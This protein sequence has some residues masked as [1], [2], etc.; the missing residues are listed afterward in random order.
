MALPM[1]L[2]GRNSPGRIIAAVGL[3]LI[4]ISLYRD[5]AERDFPFKLG[6]AFVAGGVFVLAVDLFN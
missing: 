1:L 2:V 3:V 4:L 6:W 5:P